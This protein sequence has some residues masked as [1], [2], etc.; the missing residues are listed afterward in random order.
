M[1][2][3]AHDPASELY[4]IQDPPST[5]SIQRLIYDHLVHH[6]YD[7]TAS[8][9]GA[10]CKL[11]KDLK[12]SAEDEMDLDDLTQMRAGDRMEL[13]T[14]RKALMQLVLIGLISKVSL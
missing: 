6:C 2:Q 10:S 3:T 9:F 8:A 4:E 5:S 12:E 7:Q 13:L 11:D 14:K 1:L